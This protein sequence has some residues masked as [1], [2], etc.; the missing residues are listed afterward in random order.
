VQCAVVKDLASCARQ[1]AVRSAVTT[2]TSMQ[3]VATLGILLNT[4]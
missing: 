4:T 1:C 3:A 2:G